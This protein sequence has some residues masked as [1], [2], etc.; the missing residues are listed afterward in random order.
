MQAS[1]FNAVIS[2]CSK[3]IHQR[4]GLAKTNGKVRTPIRDILAD[5]VKGLRRLRPNWTDFIDK[6]K[7]IL[8]LIDAWLNH[9]VLFRLG[10][11]VAA[12]HDFSHSTAWKTFV[13]STPALD[14]QRSQVDCLIRGVKKLSM[15]RDV[16]RY[17]YRTAKRYPISRVIRVTVV[18]LPSTMFARSPQEDHTSELE[19]VFR[20]VF[21]NKE[22]VSNV[23]RI[24]GMCQPVAGC[25]FE[26]STRSTR[27]QPAIHAEV[28]LLAYCDHHLRGMKPRVICSSKEACFLCDLLIKTHSKMYTPY[29]HGRLYPAWRLP[30]VRGDDRLANEFTLALQRRLEESLVRM[31][32]ANRRIRNPLPDNES[33][34]HTLLVSST[35]LVD[36]ESGPEEG[37]QGESEY[38]GPA[39]GPAGSAVPER[40][41]AVE[42]G[43]DTP[44]D[45]KL[46][47]SLA[48]PMTSAHEG[49]VSSAGIPTDVSAIKAVALN[50]A[51]ETNANATATCSGH[52]THVLRL[53]EAISTRLDPGHENSQLFATDS[54][55]L[56]VERSEAESASS[57]GARH[58]PK[59]FTCG[60]T[61]ITAEEASIIMEQSGLLIVDI[62]TLDE[63]SLPLE[64]LTTF[65]LRDGDG[66]VLRLSLDAHSQD[67]IP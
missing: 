52:Q 32:R 55:D 53:G 41:E 14:V 12:M 18:D 25:S 49:G 6:A 42:G 23:C 16:A 39:A 21:G 65:F 26:N 45:E 44:D 40:P 59:R 1:L 4:L 51:E 22:T 2:M 34:S 29:T 30:T 10:N 63:V 36:T 15:Y 35:T 47:P 3:R 67:S 62:N 8:N 60:I 54:F 37:S 9:R 58:P 64:G 50:K 46:E 13:A 57:S 48:D 28:Q 66:C 11:I 19:Q 24:L 38:Q 43:D 7:A 27:D 17:L 20:R 56:L 5:V 31:R 33:A 61:W